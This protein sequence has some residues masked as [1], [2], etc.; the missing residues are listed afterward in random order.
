M[1]L[2]QPSYCSV[3]APFVRATPS[4]VDSAF[5][6]I[7]SRIFLFSFSH[8]ISFIWIKSSEKFSL[9]LLLLFEFSHFLFVLCCLVAFCVVHFIASF[10]MFSSKIFA[11]RLGFISGLGVFMAAAVCGIPIN[12]V[13]LFC[14]NHF[15]RNKKT[16]LTL[17]RSGDDWS[18][19]LISS[20]V[21]TFA[22]WLLC[23]LRG[24]ESVYIALHVHTM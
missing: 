13:L 2:I 23:V 17:S 1:S 18:W 19:I 8:E 11:T 4:F 21:N 5:D 12:G 20:V 22:W 6:R 24:G 16:F 3:E 9:L 10:S 15:R 7:L 14:R